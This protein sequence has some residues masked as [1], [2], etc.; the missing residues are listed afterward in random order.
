M[1]EYLCLS[2]WTKILSY[3]YTL[4]VV[5]NSFDQFTDQSGVDLIKFFKETLN[6]NAKDRSML[7]KIEKELYELAID[8]T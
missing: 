3:L 1:L 4:F 8:R 6:K 7:L 2:V 5:E